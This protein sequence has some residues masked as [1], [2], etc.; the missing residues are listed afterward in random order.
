MQRQERA[1]N[2]GRAHVLRPQGG[3]AFDAPGGGRRALHRPSASSASPVTAYHP[4]V[5][6]DEEV[7]DRARRLANAI[8]PVVGQVY[9]SPECH[10]EYEALGFAASPAAGAAGATA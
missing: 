2:G 8:E 5:L 9:F 7:S 3:Q 4:A 10:A 6:R 1:C